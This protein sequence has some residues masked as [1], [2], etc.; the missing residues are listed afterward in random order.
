MGVK[1]KKLQG[2]EGGIVAQTGAEK[3]RKRVVVAKAAEDVQDEEE[4]EE[5]KEISRKDRKTLKKHTRFGE[6]QKPLMPKEAKKLQKMEKQQAEKQLKEEQ[7]AKQQKSMPMPPKAS[8]GNQPAIDLLRVYIGGFPSNVREYQERLDAVREKFKGFGEL[9]DVEV[10]LDTRKRCMTMAFVK[11]TSEEAVKKAM[12]QTGTELM[13]VKIQVRP[14]F[15]PKPKKPK[16]KKPKPNKQAQ[17][18]SKSKSKK[19]VPADKKR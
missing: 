16:P 10:P 5:T 3:K 15:M 12:T 19:E 17:K 2:E 8:D 11:Y 4:L 1:A 7:N 9:T 14:A 18:K 6:E 13:G